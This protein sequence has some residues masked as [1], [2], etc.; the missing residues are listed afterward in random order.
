MPTEASHIALSRGACAMVVIVEAPLVMGI[1]RPRT[2]TF[3]YQGKYGGKFTGFLIYQPVIDDPDGV[4][5]GSFAPCRA[6][7]FR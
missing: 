2:L 3:R 5:H 4:R 7:K 1:G 6:G